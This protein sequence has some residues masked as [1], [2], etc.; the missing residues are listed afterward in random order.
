MPENFVKPSTIAIVNIPH[1]LDEDSHFAFSRHIL[2]PQLHR[3]PDQVLCSGSCATPLRR[4][5]LAP[6]LFHDNAK[7]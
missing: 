7:H 2:I 6:L 5:E 1:N 3:A 4:D